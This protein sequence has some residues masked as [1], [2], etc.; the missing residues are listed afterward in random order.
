VYDGEVGVRAEDRIENLK[1]DGLAFG[2]GVKRKYHFV[3][4]KPGAGYANTNERKAG[5]LEGALKGS[6]GGRD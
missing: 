3:G 6:G 1:I 4:G 2:E 5:P